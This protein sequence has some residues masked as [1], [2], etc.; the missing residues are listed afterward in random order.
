MVHVELV[1]NLFQID[2]RSPKASA[3]RRLGNMWVSSFLSNEEVL[4]N[5]DTH[6][7]WEARPQTFEPKARLGRVT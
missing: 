7:M 2:L 6:P 3:K 4:F 5:P 1:G